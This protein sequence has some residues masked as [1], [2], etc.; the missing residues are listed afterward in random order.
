[1]RQGED[2]PQWVVLRLS[3]SIHWKRSIHSSTLGV[4]VWIFEENF[5]PLPV[6]VYEWIFTHTQESLFYILIAVTYNF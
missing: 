5:T 4:D 2:T 1:M 3:Y 6:Q